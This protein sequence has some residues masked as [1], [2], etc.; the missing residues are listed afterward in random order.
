[1][2]APSTPVI[3]ALTASVVS[4]AA[5]LSVVW[6]YHRQDH[7]AIPFLAVLLTMLFLA[8]LSAIGLYFDWGASDQTTRWDGL[9]WSGIYLLQIIW[10]TFAFRYTGL[11]DV[12]PRWRFI[13]HGLIALAP[14]LWLLTNRHPILAL[15]LVLWLLIMIGSLTGGL[16]LIIR[17]ALTF[18]QMPVGQAISIMIAPMAPFLMPAVRLVP[19]T[20]IG[21][22]TGL[23]LIIGLLIGTSGLL[24]ALGYYRMFESIPGVGYSGRDQVIEHMQEGVI[25]IDRNSR[26]IDLNP[27]I[28]G[29]FD[30]KLADVAGQPVDALIGVEPSAV[31]GTEPIEINTTDGRRRFEITASNITD[32]G[33]DIGQTL[34]LRDVTERETREQRL[35]VLNR[36]LRHNLRNDLNAVTGYAELLT[37]QPS[38]ASEY[39]ARIRKL[40]SDLLGIGEKAREIEEVVATQGGR[41]S[42]PLAPVISDAAAAVRDGYPACTI[43]VEAPEENPPVN[44]SILR[45]VLRELI[46][47]ACQH[48]NADDAVTTV[49]A[50]VDWSRDYPI[51][52]MI[53]DN[54]PG[55][56]EH[57]LT[58]M[59]EGYESALEHASGLGLW[60][61]KW[62]VNTLN[63]VVEFDE[64]D[65]QGTT[66]I[67]QLHPN[68]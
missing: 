1:M 55:I 28:E 33:R 57:E 26:I 31:K 52:V 48:N 68:C 32:G 44:G 19:A 42:E 4:L 60:F 12:F 59:Q 2:P 15:F 46:E 53:S 13:P 39:A 21:I 40:A 10:L 18:K 58:P 24:V 38:K 3:L 50:L 56:P 47:N 11:G 17:S 23:A 6:L 65:P 5:L 63:G 41:Q 22:S 49:E 29:I 20:Q 64:N 36:V 54:G 37:E 27:V 30:I 9:L 16:I 67:V 8:I 66:V 61:V 62:G 35:Q 34:V 51:S 43:V 25:V 14:V 45:P 7:S